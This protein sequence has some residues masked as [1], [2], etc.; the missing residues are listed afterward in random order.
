MY[1]SHTFIGVLAL[2]EYNMVN[3]FNLNISRYIVKLDE[4]DKI[5][6]KEAYSEMIASQKEFEESQK[7]MIKT[8]E[9]YKII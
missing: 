1:V 2:I 9:K 8:L 3:E 7:N 6:L 5:T 4:E